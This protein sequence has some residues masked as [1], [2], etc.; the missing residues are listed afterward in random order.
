M[1]LRVELEGGRFY[2]S[3]TVIMKDDDPFLLGLVEAHGLKDNIA[4]VVVRM[5][6]LA[7]GYQNF[8]KPTKVPK[9]GPLNEV[10][11]CFD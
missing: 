1:I 6:R 2:A 4:E 9:A 3:S 5:C 10:T 7:E 8:G 11:D